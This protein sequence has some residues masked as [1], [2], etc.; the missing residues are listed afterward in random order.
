MPSLQL[1][2]LPL[3]S[4]PPTPPRT[5]PRTLPP[6][7]PPRT[8]PLEGREPG[9]EPG[10]DPGGRQSAIEGLPNRLGVP[11]GLLAARDG[12]CALDMLPMRPGP[13]S[14]RGGRTERIA[15]AAESRRVRPVAPSHAS[16]LAAELGASASAKL[17]RVD[18]G[19]AKLRRRG[20]RKTAALSPVTAAE[21][22]VP[23]LEG[24]AASSGS[25]ITGVEADG[26]NADADDGRATGTVG[27]WAAAAA[28]ASASLRRR[29]GG[30]LKPSSLTGSCCALLRL[31]VS[32]DIN[33]LMRGPGEVEV[34]ASA[35]AGDG[36]GLSSRRARSAELPNVVLGFSAQ[37]HLGRGGRAAARGCAPPE[38]ARTAG[39]VLCL[40][41]RGRLEPRSSMPHAAAA[42]AAAAASS[43]A[44]TQIPKQLA[45][46]FAAYYPHRASARAGEWRAGDPGR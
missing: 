28:L 27:V 9:H 33:V 1:T 26:R 4:Q 21:R 6:P 46:Q 38:G 37:L 45:E 32:V 31:R 41:H 30:R 42:V 19:V 17:L 34:G 7:P 43:A 44:N 8:P 15:S 12:S 40:R 16:R 13:Q 25:G 3:A 36:S 14:G 29:A 22:T 39:G 24:R 10:R 2:S 11:K 35:G 5:P 20:S 18:G 23:P